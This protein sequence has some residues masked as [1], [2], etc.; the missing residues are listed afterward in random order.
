MKPEAVPLPPSPPLWLEEMSSYLLN[1]TDQVNN[2]N[3]NADD[4]PT[5][6]SGLNNL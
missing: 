1:S 4:S 6:V 5:K 2:F 3:E